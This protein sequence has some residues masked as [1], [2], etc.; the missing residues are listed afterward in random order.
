LFGAG[1]IVSGMTQPENVLS[2]LDL[3]GDWNPTLA[4][5][6]IGA[7]GVHCV[8]YRFILRRPAPL[9]AKEFA[10]PAPGAIDARLLLGAA[11]F[12]AGW[13]LAGYCPGPSVVSLASGGGGAWVFVAAMAAGMLIA[14]KLAYEESVTARGRS[15]PPRLPTQ[16][17]TPSESA[18]LPTRS[19]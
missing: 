1:L 17:T 13:G 12:G 3:F 10:V 4:F 7:I 5:V 15:L 6:M 2:F 14:S 9:L 11:V 19:G 18:S 8:A 16:S